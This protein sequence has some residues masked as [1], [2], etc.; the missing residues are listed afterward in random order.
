MD[1]KWRII[2]LPCSELNLDIQANFNDPNA[3]GLVH[4]TNLINELDAFVPTKDTKGLALLLIREKYINKD[5]IGMI[6]PKIYQLLDQ[7]GITDFKVIT[8]A[9]Q[10]DD[11]IFNQFNNL[12]FCHSFLLRTYEKIGQRGHYITQWNRNANKELFLTGKP[13]KYQRIG[14]A[15]K[16][17]LKPALHSSMDWSFFADPNKLEEYKAWI[18]DQYTEQE[19]NDF[20][21]SFQRNLD[22]ATN[23]YY[24]ES[25]NFYGYD[26]DLSL[27]NNT[28][29]S[30]I[31]ETEFQT[32]DYLDVTSTGD[33]TNPYC[34]ISEK[35]WKTIL[36]RHPFIMA[37]RVDIIPK[38]K[39]LGFRT[40]ENYLKLPN[41]YSIEDMNDRLNAIVENTEHYIMN[42]PSD[43]VKNQINDDVEFNFTQLM[44]LIN[45]EY[46]KLINVFSGSRQ[47]VDEI[48]VQN[49]TETN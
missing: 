6:L 47:T 18:L 11:N 37:G 42:P 26:Y 33:K 8:N 32:L 34:V 19:Y 24:Q 17:Y 30:V 14:L 21:N 36:N 12:V 48:I 20:I 35:T 31:S 46:D 4:L 2:E 28:S 44:S 22:P 16:F 3:T 29:L 9:W 25:M 41:Y 39:S 1:K 38:L 43:E 5:L 15:F 23:P 49:L 27:F 40:F 10:Y 7:R 45:G 13:Y